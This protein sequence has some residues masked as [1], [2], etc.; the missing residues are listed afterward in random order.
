MYKEFIEKTKK[1]ADVIIK[2]DSI[3]NSNAFAIL[4]NEI[5]KILN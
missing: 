5:N 1:Y 2:E 3:V 4:S